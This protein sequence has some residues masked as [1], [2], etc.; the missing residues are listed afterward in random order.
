[1]CGFILQCEEH[2][3]E[4]LIQYNF[5]ELDKV[6]EMENDSTCG[7]YSLLPF[8]VSS[9]RSD[10]SVRYCRDNSQSWT[11]GRICWKNGKKG[12][13]NRTGSFIHHRLFIL[14]A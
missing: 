6:H 1:M 5:V 2:V 10:L 12:V 8:H 11:S 14:F 3:G 13:H 7:I 4:E 9:R